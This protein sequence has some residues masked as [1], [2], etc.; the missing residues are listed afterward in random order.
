MRL[1]AYSQHI[2]LF[3]YE[4]Y[5]MNL[6]FMLWSILGAHEAEGENPV[7]NEPRIS[8]KAFLFCD[9]HSRV[10]KVCSGASAAIVRTCHLSYSLVLLTVLAAEFANLLGMVRRQTKCS[11]KYFIW[12]KEKSQQRQLSSRQIKNQS[13]EDFLVKKRR[14]CKM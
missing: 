7:G 10:S 3:A 6:I 1:L 4:N 12:L 14:K 8:T 2:S 5:P 11:C 13:R 9:H